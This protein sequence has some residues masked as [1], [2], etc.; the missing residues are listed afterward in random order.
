MAVLPAFVLSVFMLSYLAM[1]VV[2]PIST[3][4]NVVCLFLFVATGDL[5]IKMVAL[6][7]YLSI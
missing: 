6:G 5:D 1:F 2:K 7:S 4:L 3:G